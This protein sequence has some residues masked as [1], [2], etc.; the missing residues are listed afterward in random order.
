[1]Q[2]ASKAKNKK[3][4]VSET[5]HLLQDFAKTYGGVYV[6]AI[7]KGWKY[8]GQHVRIELGHELGAIYLTVADSSSDSSKSYTVGMKF[9]FA[10]RRKL[11]FHLCRS[12]R[13]LFLPF[14]PQLRPVTLPN[15]AMNKQFHAKASHPG[16]LRSILKQEG[17]HET[18]ES[19]PRAYIK[20]RPHGGKAVLSVSESAKKPD[21]ETLVRAAGLMKLMIAALHEQGFIRGA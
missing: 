13:P 9:E 14:R 10:S 16:L 8:K 3:W 19:C 5:T 12:K 18:L 20:L 7:F 17:L 11:E 21:K 6:P 4:W 2:A 15:A 1:M